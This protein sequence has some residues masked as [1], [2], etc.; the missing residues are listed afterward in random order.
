MQ[1]VDLGLLRSE[2]LGGRACGIVPV[3]DRVELGARSSGP[4]EQLVV[5][6]RAVAPAEARDPVECAL[7]LL[8]PA[9][10]GLERVEEPG[11][12]DRDV[13]QRELGGAERL[14]GGC[15][16]GRDALDRR[17]RPLG[18]GDK[19]GGAVSLVARD[20]LERRGGGLRQL[21]DVA[22]LLPLRPEALL[23]PG[24]QAFRVGHERSQLLEPCLGS[25]RVSA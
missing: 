5:A 3:G 22:K 20:G 7:D 25:R 23:L 1:T 12:I 2:R 9:R 6:E 19:V 4:L 17:D 15:Q 24:L 21:G 10:L 11:E 8:H 14:A 13:A 18:G 16:L